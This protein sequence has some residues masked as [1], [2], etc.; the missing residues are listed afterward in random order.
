MIKRVM[1]IGL[2]WLGIATGASAQTMI[3]EYIH[4]DAL[5]SPVAV[6]D[7]SGQVIPGR[8]Q[9]YEPYGASIA[10]GATDGPGYTGH[11][12]DSATGLTYMQQRYY[13]PD[14]GRFLSVDPVTA[15][16]STGANFNSYK[17]AAN[18][19]FRFTDPDGR[20][21]KVTGSNI[22]GRAFAGSRLYGP[23]AVNTGNNLDESGNNGSDPNAAPPTKVT[24]Q[25]AFEHYEGG[26]G[27]ALRVNFNDVDTS[28]VKPSDFNDVKDLISDGQNGLHPINDRM[29][30]STVG[31]HK[32]LLGN[33]TL[34]LQGNLTL[35]DGGFGFSGTLKSYDDK[36]DFNQ[37][38]HRGIIGELLTSA[39]RSTPGAP[40]PVEIRGAKAIEEH[41]SR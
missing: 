31:D 36:Y 38:T 23:P 11:V 22:A 12:E 8:S 41:G 24:T 3:V 40:F 5:G 15:N 2:G 25:S 33:I 4:T 30:Y 9:V 13:D 6:T 14:V 29:A 19:P 17:Y 16:G 10:H 1:C 32:L 27:T 34:R 35:T 20:R 18:N 37:S 7:A 39:G 26:S 21:E 28:G